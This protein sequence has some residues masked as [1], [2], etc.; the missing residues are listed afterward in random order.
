[1]VVEIGRGSEISICIRD[2]A[3]GREFGF[4]YGEHRRGRNAQ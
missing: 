3:S 2:Q 1:M 4:G